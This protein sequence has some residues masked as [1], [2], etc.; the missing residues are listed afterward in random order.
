MVLS[1]VIFVL[2]QGLLYVRPFSSLGGMSISIV[3][4]NVCG[5]ELAF[6]SRAFLGFQRQMLGFSVNRV[7]SRQPYKSQVIS[8]LCV[9]TRISPRLHR[10]HLNFGLPRRWPN[11]ADGQNDFGCRLRLQH[12]SESD[13]ASGAE[14]LYKDGGCLKWILDPGGGAE[15]PQPGDTVQVRFTMWCDGQ[16]L[17]SNED[18]EEPFEF[19]LVLALNA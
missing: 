17:S 9:G 10:S 18:T 11:Q 5:L 7:P 8:D 6:A 4:M 19:E 14:D 16:I 15:T 13:V 1:I 12:S 2:M 3:A